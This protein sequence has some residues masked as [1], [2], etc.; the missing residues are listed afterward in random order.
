M[1]SVSMA[2]RLNAIKVTTKRE[3]RSTLYG[4]GLYVVMTLIFLGAAYLSIRQSLVSV[5]ENGLMV[6]PN[7]ITQPFFLTV[8]LASTYLGLCAAIAISR[9]RDQ[10]TL[11]VLFYGPVDTVSYV[12]GKYIH[13]IL[14]FL[15]MLAFSV[16]NFVAVSL[17][18]NL[19]FS[20]NFIGILLLSVF[21]ASCMISF[22]I[23]LSAITRRMVVSI[24]L[25]LGLVLF[26]IAFWVAHAW[27]MSIPGK[28]LT[29]LTIFARVVLDNLNTVLQWI[30]PLSYL[31]RGSTAIAMGNV[32]QYLLSI[33]SSVLYTVVLLGLSIYAFERKGV[34]R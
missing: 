16:I 10:G 2:Y 13:Q 20:R 11:E 23:F 33:V 7:P 18:T 31:A 19:G 29:T 14:A 8:G 6:L 21:L 32:G 5:V 25:F 12:L 4:L 3:L 30:S 22:G 9:E 17:V 27:V 26:F 34:R 24:I 1:G 15:V 28:D